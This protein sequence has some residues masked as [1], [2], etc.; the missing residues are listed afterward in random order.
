M[1]VKFNLIAA[2]ILIVGLAALI[3]FYGGSRYKDGHR[4]GVS[5]VVQDSLKVD[6]VFVDVPVIEYEWIV[7]KEAEV[8]TVDK[9]ITYSTSLDSTF[10]VDKDTVAVLKHDISFAEGIF[11]ILTNIEIR[12]VEKL[13]IKTEYKTIEIL[14]PESNPFYNT[15]VFGIILTLILQAIVALAF[16]L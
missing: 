16:I 8:D 1:S 10:V 6:T 14:V 2:G 3:Y 9:V 4:D 5:S 11:E 12:P 13:I 7:I 15:T